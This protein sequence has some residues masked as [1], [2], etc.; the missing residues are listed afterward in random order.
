MP[1]HRR[2]LQPRGKVFEDTLYTFSDV[3]ELLDARN[4]VEPEPG[5]TRARP[6]DVRARPPEGG[7][8]TVHT[9]QV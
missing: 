3:P 1:T 4:P 5:L 2:V 9:A 6:P 7:R 8:L